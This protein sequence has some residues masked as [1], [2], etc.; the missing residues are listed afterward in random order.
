M[1]YDKEKALRPLDLTE[2][3]AITLNEREQKHSIGEGM[4]TMPSSEY[5]ELRDKYIEAVE[6]VNYMFETKQAYIKINIALEHTC[7]SQ[8]ERIFKLRNLV[9]GMD[10]P[11]PTCPEYRE[12]HEDITKILQYID[13]YLLDVEED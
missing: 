4:H 9:W 11:S 7:K 5:V 10:I 6:L 13:T 2:K 3:D 1:S 8:R 12:H